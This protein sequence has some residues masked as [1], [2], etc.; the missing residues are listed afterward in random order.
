MGHELGSLST[1]ALETIY[2]L[3]V[4][5]LPVSDNIGHAPPLHPSCRMREQVALERHI[6]TQMQN[7]LSG[8]VGEK[9]CQED[10]QP[11]PP[12]CQ[13]NEYCLFVPAD[14]SK[15]QCDP[16]HSDM[17]PLIY[18]TPPVSSLKSSRFLVARG[19]KQTLAR[20]SVCSER[21][22]LD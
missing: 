12:V 10:E 22:G 17:L 15:T 1:S 11:L 6:T 9:H 7:L 3:F 4:G 14:E 20:C 21:P 5:S 18:R 13:D 19:T 2:R 16:L 8:G